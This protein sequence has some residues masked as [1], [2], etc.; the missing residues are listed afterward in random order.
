VPRVTEQ[1]SVVW[2]LLLSG[3]LAL[4]LALPP[5]LMRRK[6]RAELEALATRKG[7]RVTP[8][9][10]R[11]GDVIS[12][13][14]VDDGYEVTVRSDSEAVFVTRLRRPRN[15][16]TWFFPRRRRRLGGRGARP[17]ERPPLTLPRHFR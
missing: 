13:S 3:L 10:D 12:V 17:R 5:W 16:P 2:A 4:S 11:D 14:F 7:W 1:V 6:A 8:L 15:T 9:W